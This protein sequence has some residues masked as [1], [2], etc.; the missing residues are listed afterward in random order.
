MINVGDYQG[1]QAI[2]LSSAR[3]SAAILPARGGKV[4]S[5]F[6]KEKQF[7]FLFQNP[8]SV[9]SDAKTGDDF[10]LFEACGLDDAFPSINS[11]I[12]EING[13]PVAYP[14]HGEIWSAPFRFSIDGDIARLWYRSPLLGYSYQKSCQLFDKTL[15]CT[16]KIVNEGCQSFPY[17]WALHGLAVYRPDMQIVFPPGVEKVIN[18]LQSSRLGAPESEYLFPLD[19]PLSSPYD[20]TS[21]PSPDSMTM[22]KYFVKGRVSEGIAG[23]RYPR[24]SVAV[25]L[26]YDSRILPYL[27]FWITAG[28]FRGDCN[29]ALEPMTGFYD[30][31]RIASKNGAINYLEPGEAL[32]FSINFS[33]VTL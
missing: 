24:E 31:I 18:V 10:A 22:E 11:G 12:V 32:N 8:R 28:G 33:F 7:E 2:L 19:T 26:Q 27:G 4:A 3:A 6:D 23:Y 25:M 15:S 14:D 29:C 9:Y 30:D 16:W 5:F 21:V 1:E 13:S 17:L 20:F